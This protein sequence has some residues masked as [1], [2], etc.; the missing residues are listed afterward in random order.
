MQNVSVKEER[1]VERYGEREQQKPSGPWI[2]WRHVSDLSRVFAVGQCRAQEAK[3][4]SVDC[5]FA[6]STFRCVACCDH[7]T[8]RLLWVN[9]MCQAFKRCW[10]LLGPLQRREGLQ[11]ALPSGVGGRPP[12]LGRILGEQWAQVGG[13]MSLFSLVRLAASVILTQLVCFLTRHE[14]LFKIN[15][16]E[17]SEFSEHAMHLPLHGKSGVNNWDPAVG[18]LVMCSR[19]RFGN[20]SSCK[21]SLLSQIVEASGCVHGKKDVQRNKKMLEFII[22]WSGMYNTNTSRFPNLDG[23]QR[24]GG[25][26]ASSMRA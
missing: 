5:S 3:A 7:G 22:S 1:E 4:S 23:Y 13:C 18:G 24:G 6:V 12:L 9:R 26:T 8:Q 11:E 16:Y 14:I 2:W 21:S 19:L 15:G 20:L 25:D 17:I 10:R